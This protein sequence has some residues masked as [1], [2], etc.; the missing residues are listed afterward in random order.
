TTEG[1]SRIDF[2]SIEVEPIK[3]GTGTATTAT[4]TTSTTTTTT[5]NQLDAEQCDAFTGNKNG[6]MKVKVYSLDG[7]CFK[8]DVDGFP[9][10]N[11]LTSNAI[12]Y[13]DSGRRTYAITT[14]NGSRYEGKILVP[15]TIDYD[16]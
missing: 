2:T 12:I 9:V 14:S 6:A 7:V 8:L 15:T 3:V 5:N 16:Q 1:I 13:V 10:I 11:Q 4:T